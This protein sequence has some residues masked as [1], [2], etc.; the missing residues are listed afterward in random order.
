MKNL[1]SLFISVLIITLL[2]SCGSSPSV[3]SKI[4]FPE[5][6]KDDTVQTVSTS[7]KTESSKTSTAAAVTTETVSTAPAEIKAPSNIQTESDA[8]TIVATW[9]QVE[10]A[11]AYRIY[12]YDPDTDDYI[13]FLE[14][15]DIGFYVT[16]LASGLTYIFKVAS[17]TGT[18][19]NYV[20]HGISEPIAVATL[21]ASSTNAAAGTRMCTICHGSGVC[22]VCDGTGYSIAE[23]VHGYRPLCSSCGGTK[24]CVACD[25]YG[26]Y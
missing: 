6:S 20:E 19:G 24:R 21:A 5:T 13:T 1:K 3:S 8:V 23:I 22:W 4:S 17:L 15:E 18:E 10:G 2:A 9:D 25:G 12:S 11:D 26:Y 7:R 14:I 16:G